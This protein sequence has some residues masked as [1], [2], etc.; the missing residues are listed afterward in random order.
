MIDDSLSVLTLT[1]VVVFAPICEITKPTA[2]LKTFQI[3]IATGLSDD[4]PSGSN[5]SHW[6]NTIISGST[7]TE[8]QAGES[9]DSIDVCPTPKNQDEHH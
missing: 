6:N 7:T 9:P 4:N 8:V 5:Q 1:Y 3:N 2:A